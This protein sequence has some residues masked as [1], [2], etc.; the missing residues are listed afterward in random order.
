MASD[1][2][3]TVT[4]TDYATVYEEPIMTLHDRQNDGAWTPDATWV[5]TFT[6]P[7][8]TPTSPTLTL[9]P[10]PTQTSKPTNE[11]GPNPA[12]KLWIIFGGAVGGIALLLILLCI[13]LGIKRNK[14]DNKADRSGSQDLE[15]GNTRNIEDTATSSPRVVLNTDP[16]ADPNANT[17]TTT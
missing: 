3:I 11:G 13:I 17:A 1:K 16:N 15:A 2:K 7:V 12:I 4:H 14:K 6:V 9:T 10:T 8:W 5:P